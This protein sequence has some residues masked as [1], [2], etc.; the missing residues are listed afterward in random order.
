MPRAEAYAFLYHYL[1]LLKVPEGVID[2]EAQL[3][4]HL[5]RDL[6]L[7]APTTQLVARS[8][9]HPALVNLFMQAAEEVTNRVGY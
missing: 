9:L 5:L 2:F 1:Y 7:V 3:S 6:T 8:D 4:R